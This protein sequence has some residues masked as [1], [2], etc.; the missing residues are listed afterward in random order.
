MKKSMSMTRTKNKSNIEDAFLYKS[1]FLMKKIKLYPFRFFFFFFHMD[2]TDE[3]YNTNILS[4]E[5][6]ISI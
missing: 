4:N 3:I 2:F 6:N 1:V 5:Y